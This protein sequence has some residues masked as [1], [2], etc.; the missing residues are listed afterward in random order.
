[1]EQ[2][3]KILRK[4]AQIHSLDLIYHSSGQVQ[5]RNAPFICKGNEYLLTKEKEPIILLYER[6]GKTLSR[7]RSNG[8]L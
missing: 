2:E 8:Y 7:N 4:P 6:N 1:M 5:T 3:K